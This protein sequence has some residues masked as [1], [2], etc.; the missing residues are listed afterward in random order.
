M[1]PRPLVRI[2]HA[3][4][5]RRLRLER[6]LAAGVDLIETDL[7]FADG[8]VWVRHEHRLRRLPLLYNT[9]LRGIHREGP[10]A[11][12]A[13]PLY[14]RLDR[15]PIRF[16]EVV[17]A[18]SGRGGLMLD[19]KAGRY[20]PAE[21]ARFIETVLE[22]LDAARFAGRLDFCGSWRLLDEVRLR[23]PTQTVHFSVDGERDWSTFRARAGGADEIRGITIQRRL[24]TD[25]R[26]A[27]LREAGVDFYCWDIEDPADAEHAIAQGAAGVI[28]DDLDLLRALAGR[29]VRTEAAA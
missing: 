20:T 25:E 17:A 3:Y 13:G 22:T 8:I 26:G 7:R 23:A 27:F 24:L 14:L 1:S 21:A 29:P 16:P 11:V 5:N 18:V 4:G 19:L 28:A 9:R 2:A 12:A 10:L 15:T 6:V